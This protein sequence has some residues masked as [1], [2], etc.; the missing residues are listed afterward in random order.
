MHN[1]EPLTK[2]LTGTI[3]QVKKKKKKKNFIGVP[4]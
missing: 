4:C 3:P 2:H 1:F